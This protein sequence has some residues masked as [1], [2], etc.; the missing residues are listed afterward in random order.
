MGAGGSD[1]RV[2]ASPL[3]A[4][5]WR[6]GNGSQHL[7]PGVPGSVLRVGAWYLCMCVHTRVCIC[8]TGVCVC[9]RVYVLCVRACTSMHDCVSVCI[10]CTSVCTCVE[11]HLCM[12]V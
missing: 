1:H 11:V 10:V 4:L 2:A 6:L 5:A 3:V 12:C 7:A 8:T 9:T